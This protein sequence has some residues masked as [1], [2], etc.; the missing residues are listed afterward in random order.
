MLFNRADDDDDA[1]LF[2]K[3]KS[4]QCD[5][6]DPIWDT[7]SNGAKSL[8]SRMLCVD[9]AQRLKSAECL[10]DQWLRSN[11]AAF[12]NQH[13]GTS[14]GA[15]SLQ[16]RVPALPHVRSERQTVSV[17]R[18][19]SARDVQ[20]HG[21]PQG[22]GDVGLIYAPGAEMQRGSR[23]ASNGSGAGEPGS[24]SAE[25][26]AYVTGDA[27]GDL[28]GSNEGGQWPSNDQATRADVFTGAETFSFQ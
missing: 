6:E 11:E 5:V 22:E 19:L 16:W 23:G 13:R 3:I 28:Q 27:A 8:V 12:E 4:G 25:D 21:L 15:S 1:V 14:A 20:R 18:L 17:T 24:S 26:V 10:Q 7:I 2:A 9:A